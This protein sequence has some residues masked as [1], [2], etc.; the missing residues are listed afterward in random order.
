M[1]KLFVIT[2]DEPFYIPKMIKYL[3][4]NQFQN[5]YELVGYTVLS[6]NRKNKSILHWV[7]ERLRIYSLWELFLVGTAFAIAKIITWLKIT[8]YYSCRNILKFRNIKEIATLDIN[9]EYYINRIKKENPDVILSISCP[10]LFKE[11]L[12]NTPNLYCINAHGTLLPRHR[13]VFGS[14]WTLYYGDKYGG[15]TLHTMELKL[16]AG[17]IIWQDSFIVDKNDTQ[18]SIAYK[19]KKQMAISIVQVL[20]KLNN[21]KNIKFTKS[22]YSSSYH[23]APNREEGKTFRKNAN[24]ILTFDNLK[25]MLKHKF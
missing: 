5:K 8:N 21:E 6:P 12:L 18:F 13:G 22:Q 19:T 2:Q 25:L 11:G 1:I 7:L 9:D 14:F 17:E 15:S 20:N 10:Q 4:E 3:V 23:R 16:D 24:K